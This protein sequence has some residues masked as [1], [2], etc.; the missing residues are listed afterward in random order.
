MKKLIPVFFM[1]FSIANADLLVK[2]QGE[3]Y[4]FSFV[5]N[6]VQ[7]CWVMPEWVD[8]NYFD[9]TWQ[10]VPNTAVLHNWP[11]PTPEQADS[12]ADAP[13]VPRTI[14]GPLYTIT[15]AMQVSAIGTVPAGV[16]CGDAIMYY[17][18]FRAIAYNGQVGFAWCS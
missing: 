14:G 17:K 1:F 16:I 15:Y 11:A 9:Y 6:G 7:S 3:G 10:T 2:R 18:F 8:L 4:M 13:P 12:C 5:E